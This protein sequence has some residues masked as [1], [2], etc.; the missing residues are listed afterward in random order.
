MILDKSINKSLLSLGDVIYLKDLKPFWYQNFAY[1]WSFLNDY[2]TAVMG[3]RRHENDPF[4]N[5]L[6][7]TILST[8]KDITNFVQTFHPF[9]IRSIISRLNN[10]QI[11][12]HPNFRI[13]HSALF[14]PNWLCNVCI[15]FCLI[16]SKFK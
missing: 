7:R 3:L 1:R 9:R 10:G 14:D 11:Y 13:Y 4:I 2:N 5:D 15:P 16:A 8:V 6:Y 12:T